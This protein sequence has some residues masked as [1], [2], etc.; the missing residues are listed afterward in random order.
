MSK[1][2]DL[3]PDHISGIIEMA[4]S[5]HASFAD[6]QREYGVSDKQVKTL[7]RENLKAGSYKAWRKRV[8]AFGDRRAVYK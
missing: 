7:M 3:P 8:R 5:D 1:M 2:P 6:I 4:L